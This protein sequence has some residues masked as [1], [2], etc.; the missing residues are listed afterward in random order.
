MMKFGFR[1]AALAGSLMAVSA[2]AMAE[3]NPFSSLSFDGWAAGVYIHRLDESADDNLATGYFSHPNANTFEFNQA[4]I[5]IDKAAT[6]DSRAGFH[7][8]YVYGAVANAQRGNVTSDGD[9]T[10]IY[11]A[12]VSYLADIGNGVNF[13][14]GR[15]GTLL[16][17]EV[18]Q[19]G[20][21]FNVTRGIVYG[22]QPITHTGLIAS[23]D[24]GGGW[25]GAIGVVNDLY[26]DSITDTSSQ[27]VVTGQLSWTGDSV[28]AGFSAIYG[29]DDSLVTAGGAAPCFP[30]GDCQLGVFDVLVTADLSDT[31]SVWLNAD[32]LVNNGDDQSEEGSA[33]GIAAAGRVAL[34]ERAGL[35]ARFEYINLDEDFQAAAAGTPAAGLDEFDQ[36]S[37][38]G[39]YDYTLTNNLTVRAEIRYDDAETPIFAGENGAGEDSQ[40]TALLEVVYNIRGN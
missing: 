11:T 16:G 39:T 1:E 25:G 34:N 23:T 6:E 35:S 14:F 4:W 2:G 27:K 10:L 17:A 5:A 30:Q 26:S 21:N 38:T 37:I 32:Y 15:V 8:D 24:F 22:L 9:D 28:Y 29:R 33:Y 18:L 31:V 19:T 40:V 36:F 12:Y 13:D 20:D 3:D 7:L